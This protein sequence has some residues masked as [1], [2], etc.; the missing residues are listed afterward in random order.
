M[1]ILKIHA[2]KLSKH[3]DI[4]YEAVVKVGSWDGSGTP[5]MGQDQCCAFCQHSHTP[6][7]VNNKTDLLGLRA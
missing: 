1:E 7:G 4:D 3:G 5:P 6:E 2:Q